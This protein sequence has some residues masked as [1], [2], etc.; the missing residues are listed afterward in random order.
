[1]INRIRNLI[2]VTL[3]APFAANAAD[4]NVLWTSGT[5]D[6]NTSMQSV[7]DRAATYDPASDGALSWNLTFWDGTYDPTFSNFDVLVIGS[8]CDEV[9]VSGT[10]GDGTCGRTPGFYGN[11]VTA[12][13]VLAYGTEIDNARGDDSRT[14]LSG[15]DADYHQLNNLPGVDDGP[16]G[17]MINAVNWAASGVG[18]GIVSM[19]D[20]IP[21]GA[22][23]G[24]WTADGSFLADEIPDSSVWDYNSQEVNI[25]P[26][27]DTFP[28]NEGLTS[29]GLS[30]WN[31][32]SHACFG[33]ISGYTAINLAPYP[34]RTSDTNC[35]VTIVT[36]GAEA[37]DTDGG[38]TSVNPVPLPA[39]AWLFG[40]AI[41][42]A[43]VVGRRKKKKA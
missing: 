22:S 17:F 36:A 9:E 32:S 40:S 33:D 6:Y 25:G 27:Q 4:I 3:V 15:Q 37:G 24:W 42:G 8:T 21:G 34:S 28:V 16:R 39:A 12:D 43:G 10:G 1:M 31:T 13:G 19:T 14:F 35:A 30:N 23:F 29:D 38:D 41:I 11:G 18:L 20:R 5:D 7:A 2:V 26:G